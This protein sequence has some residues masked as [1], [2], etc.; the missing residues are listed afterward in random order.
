MSYGREGLS[1][2][3]A[4]ASPRK[5]NLEVTFMRSSQLPQPLNLR[6]TEPYD[7]RVGKDLQDLQDHQPALLSAVTDPPR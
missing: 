5:R 1:G 2:H 3:P 4:S 6:I 7:I